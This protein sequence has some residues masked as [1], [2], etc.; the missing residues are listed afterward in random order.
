MMK[1]EVRELL[2]RSKLQKAA[3][4]IHKP[5]PICMAPRL[6]CPECIRVYCIICDLATCPRC[7]L[8]V[9]P[10]ATNSHHTNSPAST[11]TGREQPKGKN[12]R[13]RRIR[14][15]RRRPPIASLAVPGVLKGF[16][17]EITNRGLAIIGIAPGPEDGSFD[18]QLFSPNPKWRWP[19]DEVIA[20]WKQFIKFSGVPHKQGW[21]SDSFIKLV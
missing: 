19:G 9:G 17:K 2:R 11:S 20:G 6:L 13:D 5:C 7:L 8:V 18:I 15:E 1:P 21:Q 14:T 4:R 10:I 12:D 3:R 16:A